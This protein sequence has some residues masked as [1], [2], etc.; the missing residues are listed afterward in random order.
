MEL[1]SD[2]DI[3]SAGWDCAGAVVGCGLFDWEVDAVMRIFAWIGQY[4]VALGVAWLYVI[5][6]WLLY[7]WASMIALLLSLPLITIYLL[8]RWMQ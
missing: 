5:W 6:Q 4:F 2:K 8:Y 1:I 3:E 7:L